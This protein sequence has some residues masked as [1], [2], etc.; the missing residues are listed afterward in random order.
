LPD[1]TG[2]ERGGGGVVVV[3]G[4]SPKEER[5][6]NKAVRLLLDHGHDVR[7]VHPACEA[8]HGVPCVA[9]LGAVEDPV[10]TL[11]VY[12]G[13][14]RSTPL[15]DDILALAPRRIIL[16]PGAENAELARRARDSG[17]DVQEACTL[18]LL[19]TGQF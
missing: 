12:V 18:V 14:A 2:S 11:T 19:K 4:A 10:D 3:L 6:S 1:P 7:P 8:V 9:S 16:N 15:V 17:V 5:Y 13:Q